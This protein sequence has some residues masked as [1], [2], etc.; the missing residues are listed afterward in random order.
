M[1]IVGKKVTLRAIEAEDLPA[2]Q[3]WS[4]DPEINYQLGGWHFPSSMKDQKQWF[5]SLNLKS[6]HQRFAI[7]TPK[8]GLIGVANLVEINWKDRNA[9]HGLL[10]GNQEQRGQGYGTDTVMTIAKYAFHELGMKRL[11]TT[12]ISSN[13]ASLGLYLDKCGWT[14]EGLKKN[15]YFR[16]NQWL[17]MV[18]LGITDAEYAE[19]ASKLGY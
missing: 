8:D 6:N 4:N 16:K 9:F 18:I 5:D 7:D 14:Q 10:L 19:V 12:I 1:N 11:D 15:Y 17:D 2:I 3:Q 13:K